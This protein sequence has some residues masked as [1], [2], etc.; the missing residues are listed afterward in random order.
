VIKLAK[1]VEKAMKTKKRCPE[2]GSTNLF[3]DRNRGEIMCK[4]CGFIIDSGLIDFTQ[5]WREFDYEQ[6]EARRRV[7]SPL[8][9][10]RHDKGLST[11]IGKAGDLYKLSPGERRRFYRLKKWQTRISTAIER[12]LK[13]ALAELRRVSS[14][15]S[16]PKSVEEESA[17]IYRMAAE[18]GLVRGRSMESVVA[19]ALYAACR[20]QGFPRTLDEISNAFPL[21]KKEIGKTYRFVCRELGI[22]ILPTSPT[23]YINRFASELKL[24]PSTVSKSIEILQKASQKEITSG[25]GPMGIAAASLYVASLLTGEKRTQ[26]EVAEVA[27]V[28]EVTIRNR[29]KELLDK[30]SLD[31]DIKKLKASE[32]S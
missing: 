12:N 17:R 13:F 30:L 26:R 9:Y 15:L 2:C 21:D 22:R 10:T 6:V 3:W 16:I 29:Y 5:E 11:K 19:G 23:D 31:S 28:T 32:A 1:K 4:N 7:G 24:S 8:T 18:R 14:Y 25:K 27:G 20:R